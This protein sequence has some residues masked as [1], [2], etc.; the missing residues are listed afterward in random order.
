MLVRNWTRI[1]YLYT[2]RDKNE[3]SAT[4]I[5]FWQGSGGRREGVRVSFLG[6][7]FYE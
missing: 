4:N 2:T 5:F 1:V 3:P 6:P 7:S